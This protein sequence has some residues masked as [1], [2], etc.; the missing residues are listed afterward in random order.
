MSKEN[1]KKASPGPEIWAGISVPIFAVAG[2]ADRVTPSTEIQLLKDVFR[3]TGLSPTNS[4][5]DDESKGRGPPPNRANNREAAM[6]P[7][8]RDDRQRLD[9]WTTDVTAVDP[10]ASLEKMDSRGRSVSNATSR[11]FKSSILPSPAS[12]ALLYDVTTYRTLSGLIQT[13]LFDHIDS[14]LSL[15]WQLQ[16]LKEANKW[17]VKN[18]RKW[19]AVAASVGTRCGNLQSNE[20]IERG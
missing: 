12:H 11:I 10:D 17:D 20:N 6:E 14:R 16:H 3:E 7:E 4:L 18:L 1:W 9:S 15:G 8:K 2:E 19:Q 5:P 13:F